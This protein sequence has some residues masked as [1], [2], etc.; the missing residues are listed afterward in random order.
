MNTTLMRA[1]V[2]LIPATALC[3]WSF[4]SLLQL[5]GAGCLLMVALTHI[6]EAL[7]LFPWMH[8][9]EAHSAGHY[10]DLSSALLG[11]TLVPVGWFLRKRVRTA[12][13]RS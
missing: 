12:D 4:G 1:L 2:A 5:L 11:A 6:C 9:G 7:R 13:P 8:W 10:V 3:V